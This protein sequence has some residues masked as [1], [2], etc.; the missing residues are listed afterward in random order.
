MIGLKG[1]IRARQQ[2]SGPCK[3][4]EIIMNDDAI[5]G[6]CRDDYCDFETRCGHLFHDK[7]LNDYFSLTNSPWECPYCRST[8]SNSCTIESILN[9]KNSPRFPPFFLDVV[10]INSLFRIAVND[11]CAPSKLI[12][13]RCIEK[14]RWNINDPLEDNGTALIH[15]VAQKGRLDL[16]EFIISL[17][18]DVNLLDNNM[19]SPMHYATLKGD[20]DM[21]EVLMSNGADLNIQNAT[22]ETPLHFSAFSSS[23]ANYSIVKFFL[24]NGANHEICNS[25]FYTPLEASVFYGANLEI[26]DLFG[27]KGLFEN[28]EIL[29]AALLVACKTDNMAI[30]DYLIGKGADPLY[31]NISGTS[32]LHIAADFGQTKIVES[33]LNYGADIEATETY[34]STPLYSASEFG[35]FDVVK[36]LVK[37]GANL[38]TLNIDSECSPLQA[39]F[40]C[41]HFEIAKFLIDSG[42]DPTIESECRQKILKFFLK[43]PNLLENILE[44]FSDFNAPILHAICEIDDFDM[45][46]EYI[47]RGYNVE[48]LNEEGETPLFYAK[49]SRIIDELMKSSVNLDARS[50]NG[51]TPFLKACKDCNVNLFKKLADSG[52]INFKAQSKEKLNAFDYVLMADGIEMFQ[53]FVASDVYKKVLLS[54]QF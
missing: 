30:F 49:D 25:D 38:N 3:Q 4:I 13:E 10:E 52:A 35:H 21:I 28:S 9:K 7:C 19:G 1:L 5:C 27:E 46:M 12:I 31:K 32:C 51:M 43:M 33:L 40:D 22:K 53:L 47:N 45:F 34:G 24:E 29:N 16:L 6:I 48:S 44:E 2:F 37:H 18:A 39:A 26:L 50:K 17:G 11:E 41:N 15:L 14:G 54:V 20:L 23:S 36:L 8:I 42:A